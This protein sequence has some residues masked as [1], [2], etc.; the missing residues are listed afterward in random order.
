M[1]R[2]KK[3]Q[4]Q[5]PSPTLSTS[6][7]NQSNTKRRPT[8]TTQPS[9]PA[10]FQLLIRLPKPSNS[11]PVITINPSSTQIRPPKH[12]FHHPLSSP[13][14]PSQLNP[15]TSPKPTPLPQSPPFTIQVPYAPTHNYPFIAS[16]AHRYTQSPSTH[17]PPTPPTLSADEALQDFLFDPS[18]RQRVHDSGLS[19]SPTEMQRRVW[20]AVVLGVLLTQQAGGGGVVD[21]RVYLE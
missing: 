5:Q 10:P 18:D 9:P 8:L 17:S 6:P 12:F 20:K 15:S 13:Q 11:P 21:E 16:Q 4:P 2:A 3:S 19:T 1:P 7:R 14:D